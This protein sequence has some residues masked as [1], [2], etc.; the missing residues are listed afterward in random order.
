LVL[1]GTIEEKARAKVNLAL[2]VTGR[3]VD[4]YHLLDSM[5]AFADLCD[6]LTI[7]PARENSLHV[8]GPHAAGLDA[9]SNLVLH[10]Q[11]AMAQVFG[12]LIPNIAVALDKHIPL[13][14]GLGGG[15]ADAA[16][17]LRALSRLAG[18]DHRS[19]AIRSIALSL[20][21]DVPACLYSE[22]CRM[23]GIGE[24]LAPFS[25]LG[26]LHV[27]LAKAGRG[28]STGDVFAALGLA[29]GEPGYPPIDLPFDFATS[30][31]DLTPPATRLLPVVEEVMTALKSAPHVK[32]VRM[33]GSGGT[34]FALFASRDEAEGAAV[35]LESRHPD[36]WIKPAVLS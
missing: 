32:F 34:C 2:H 24:L 5:V 17:I 36:W 19:G 1:P 7:S 8:T 14:S 9:K 12:D 28:L 31:N 22:S 4:G 26:P 10:A 16:A 27:V 35:L 11:Q 13:A 21:A 18:L 30:R 25:A 20:G 6:R 33:S 23:Q 15:S 3:R 29:P